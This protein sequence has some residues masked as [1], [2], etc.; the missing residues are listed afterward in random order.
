MSKPRSEMSLIERLLDPDGD[1]NW[2]QEDQKSVEAMGAEIA[3]GFGIMT[4]V[5]PAVTC[6]GSARL[7]QD[8]P[9]CKAAA[10]IGSAL[11]KADFATI[12]GGGPGLMEAANKGAF[13]AGGKSVGL[14]IELPYE[15]GVNPYCNV[16][17]MFKYL[18]ARKIMLMKYSSG[19]IVFPGGFGTFD[20][21]FEILTMMQTKKSNPVPV[22]LYGKDY[23]QG[24]VD[25]IS[26]P[27][28][29]EGMININDFGKIR[30]TDDVEQTVAWATSTAE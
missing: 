14:A 5:G 17:I 24:L 2:S 16:S 7:A 9:Y 18:F 25:W 29:N 19:I 6:F 1:G 12:T 8:H 20:E 4:E 26:G 3:K 21:M 30:L 15:T 10:E 27:V 11:A 22:I 23:W 13:E 28:K